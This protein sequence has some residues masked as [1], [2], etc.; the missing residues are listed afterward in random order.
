MNYIWKRFN[1]SAIGI[2]VY[3][4]KDVAN[5]TLEQIRLLQ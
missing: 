5:M 3:D 1:F 4:S 2:F